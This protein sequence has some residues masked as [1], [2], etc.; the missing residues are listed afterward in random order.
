MASPRSPVRRLPSHS[1]ILLDE[2]PVEA[3]WRSAMASFSG[4][5]PT[6]HEIVD[7]VARQQM[8]D[9]EDHDRNREGHR[10]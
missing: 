10:A 8:D 1:E 3:V 9:Q 6:L 4:D 7:R 5:E 2:R